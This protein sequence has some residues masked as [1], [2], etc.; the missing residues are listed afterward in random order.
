MLR[1]LGPQ[2]VLRVYEIYKRSMQTTQTFF[3]RLWTEREWCQVYLGAQCLARVEITTDSE[4]QGLE[5]VRSPIRAFIHYRELPEIL[6]VIMLGTDPS[7]QRSGVMSGLL[8]EWIE[9]CLGPELSPSLQPGIIV[10]RNDST[11]RKAIWLEVHENNMAAI[12]LYRKFGFGEVGRRSRY[13]ADGGT[14][15]CFSLQRA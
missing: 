12:A 14:A 8:A 4:S 6:D 5:S 13:Y 1:R 11:D 15:I 2:D 10:R 7:F 3:T 9:L